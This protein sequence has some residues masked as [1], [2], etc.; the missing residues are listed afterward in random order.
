MSRMTNFKARP[1]KDGSL[2]IRLRDRLHDLPRRRGR[3]PVSMGLHPFSMAA[4]EG[5]LE[6]IPFPSN[7]SHRPKR[8]TR[9]QL[10]KTTSA[11]QNF[12]ALVGKNLRPPSRLPLSRKRM[13]NV[14]LEESR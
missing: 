9:E 10:R 12:E 8:D 13:E 1:P 11:S 3:R 5:L 2:Q 6:P 4:D 14:V 7:I